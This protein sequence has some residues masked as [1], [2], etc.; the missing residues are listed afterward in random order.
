MKKQLAPIMICALLVSCGKDGGSKSSNHGSEIQE[1]IAEGSYRAILR[2]YNNSL[3]GFLPTGKAEIKIENDMVSVKTY[4]DDDARVSHMQSIHTGTR[5]PNIS[6]DK[7]A[8]GIVDI[9]ESYA[10]AGSVL[11]PLDANINSEEEGA[12]IYPTGGGFTYEEKASL[13][14]L[15][16]DVKAH[17]KQFLNLN[18]RVVL[19]HGVAAETNMPETVAT[20]DGMSRQLSVPIAC[21]ILQRI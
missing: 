5:C 3:S 19:I 7:N 13:S 11:I 20:K 14:K 2:P 12:D 6:D 16:S 4:L 8:D 10:V 21:G 17:R 15:E 18:G 1:Q 9:I